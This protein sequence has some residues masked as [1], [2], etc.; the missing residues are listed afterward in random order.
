MTIKEGE[1]IRHYVNS[2]RPFT[3]TV[4]KNY[5]PENI[6]GKTIYF[7]VKRNVDD[8]DDDAILQK[9]LAITDGP[10]GIATLELK[11][12]DFAFDDAG[13]WPCDIKYVKSANDEPYILWRGYLSVLVPVTRKTS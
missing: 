4:T 6:T 2:Y 11:P 5:T 12:T 7:T 1:T 13:R 9:T 10:G 3:V 8:A